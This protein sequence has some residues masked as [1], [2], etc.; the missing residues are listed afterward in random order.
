MER[1][2]DRLRVTSPRKEIQ[3]ERVDHSLKSKLWNLLIDDIWGQVEFE[4]YEVGVSEH[5]GHY[6]LLKNIWHN[7]LSISY[8][9][10]PYEYKDAVKYLRGHFFDG[11]WYDPLNFI[12]FIANS[13]SDPSEAQKFCDE[14]NTTLK[15]EMSAYRFV[16][17]KLVEITS[18]VEI[19]SIE[20][21]ISVAEPFP[22]VKT[23]LQAALSKMSDKNSPD[24]RNSVKESI[25]AVES[26]VKN[27]T[28]NSNATLADGLAVLERK[29]GL[30]P[31]IKKAFGYMYG[32]TGDK[33]GIRHALMEESDL[34][35][36]DAKYM[37]VTCSAF[38]NFLISKIA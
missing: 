8:D 21:A 23:H 17:R 26:L 19:E 32:Y 36:D 11:E 5:S 20:S 24:Y 1:F 30:H 18:E 3:R 16:D 29:H 28:S 12:E 35:V 7:Y 6:G 25:S 14:A 27:I 13:F 4:L 33:G 10:I 38:V 34:D 2:S 31:A 15:I 37:L 22:G 9:T